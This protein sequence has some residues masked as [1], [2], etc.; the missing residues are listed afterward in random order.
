MGL[1]TTNSYSCNRSVCDLQEV[2]KYLKYRP[3]KSAVMFER[4]YIRPFEARQ[5][6]EEAASDAAKARQKICEQLDLLKNPS[7]REDAAK[8]IA[9]EVD[10]FH[11]ASVRAEA[12]VQRASELQTILEESSTRTKKSFNAH[13]NQL[14]TLQQ[15]PTVPARPASAPASLESSYAS[16]TSSAS[17]LWGSLSDS[18]C[19]L[20]GMDTREKV[21]LDQKISTLLQ[22]IEDEQGDVEAE[23]QNIR[24]KSQVLSQ[25]QLSLKAIKEIGQRIALDLS[26]SAGSSLSS[27]GIVVGEEGAVVK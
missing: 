4:V 7:T 12:A 9:A 1:V 16:L 23:A 5:V 25:A 18:C 24:E 6:A 21:P 22:Q 3:G 27:V 15:A 13:Q 26:G 19:S 14:E 20:I 17:R 8:T 11:R 2:S 10:K